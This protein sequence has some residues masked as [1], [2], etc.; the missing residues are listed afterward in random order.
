MRSYP[1]LIL[2]QDGKV[3][4]QYT[5]KRDLADLIEFVTSTLNEQPQVKKTFIVAMNT[6]YFFQVQASV[7][8][9]RILTGA[10]FDSVVSAGTTFVKFYAPW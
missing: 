5:G 2:L 9:V 7:P 3:K 10:D 8:Q 1:T 6:S 4:A